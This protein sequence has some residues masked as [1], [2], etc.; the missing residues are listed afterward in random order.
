MNLKDFLNIFID[1]FRKLSLSAKMVLLTFGFLLWL[2]SLLIV[3]PEVATQRIECI[4]SWVRIYTAPDNSIPINEA[5]HNKLVE[6]KGSL[7]TSLTNEIIS[8]LAKPMTEESVTHEGGWYDSWTLSQIS[9]ALPTEAH[10]YEK[11]I[12]RRIAYSVDRWGHLPEIPI[13]SVAWRI[14]A[15]STVFG[16]IDEQGIQFLLDQQNKEGWWGSFAGTTDSKYASTYATATAMIALAS[17][18]ESNK[19]TTALKPSVSNA[20]QA[21]S[22]W[23]RVNRNSAY[24]SDY[25]NHDGNV[26]AG[27]TGVVLF[28]LHKTNRALGNKESE[29][30]KQFDREFLEHIRPDHVP[31]QY[32][33]VSGLNVHNNYIDH[34]RVPFYPAQILGLVVSYRSGNTKQRTQAL[35]WLNNITDDMKRGR[36]IAIEYPWIASEY[37]FALS[38]LLDY[39][40]G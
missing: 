22:D 32:S 19:I 3:Y 40:E 26:R 11:E 35:N 24:W 21:S 9:L 38:L 12:L 7:K 34:V 4:S 37:L 13:Q 29:E 17:A 2:A 25:P 1:D 6:L 31:A 20:L 10:K 30:L 16:E 39:E 27:L 23:L 14:W 33:E 15:K 36:K 5:T 18:I 8:R 28:A